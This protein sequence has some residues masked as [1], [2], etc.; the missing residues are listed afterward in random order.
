MEHAED[1]EVEPQERILEQIR[2]LR[3]LPRPLN[4]SEWTLL[5][6]LLGRLNLARH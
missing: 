5:L 1:T 3:D 2:A 6:S 4:D